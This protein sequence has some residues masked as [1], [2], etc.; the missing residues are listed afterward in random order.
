MPFVIMSFMLSTWWWNTPT[1]RNTIAVI[2]VIMIM[3]MITNTCN[4]TIIINNLNR[5]GVGGM[6]GVRQRPIPEIAACPPCE[7]GG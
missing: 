1:P 2:I 3:I 4:H 5:E 6:G 7:A